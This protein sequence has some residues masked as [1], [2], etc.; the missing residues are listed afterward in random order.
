MQGVV[1]GRAA[2][3]VRTGVLALISSAFAVC[4]AIAPA[5]AQT[6]A[7][8]PPDGSYGLVDTVIFG[9]PIDLASEDRSPL[10]AAIPTYVLMTVDGDRLSFA[11]RRYPWPSPATCEEAGWC[12]AWVEALE[13]AIAVAP[14]GAVEVVAWRHDDGPGMVIDRADVDGPAI[15]QPIVSFFDGATVA[16]DGVGLA[17]TGRAPDGQMR[18]ARFLPASRARMEDAMAFVAAFE[19]SLALHDRCV[20]R[21][22]LEFDARSWTLTADEAHFLAATR[23][24]GA[25]WRIDGEIERLGPEDVESDAYR[26]L[27]ARRAAF[28]FGFVNATRPS[29]DLLAQDAA[30][31]WEAVRRD[32]R[33]AVAGP[34]LQRVQAEAFDE[35]VADVLSNESL[36]RG[37]GPEIRDWIAAHR[38]DILALTDYS[39]RFIYA[40]QHGV[41]LSSAAGPILCGGVFAEL[42]P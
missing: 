15:I 38:D 7:D 26:R 34:E 18:T 40:A 33:L 6:K 36:V 3:P 23:A 32:A 42:A 24:A 11:F 17:V 9:G 29:V 14:G 10:N 1:G 30:L 37:N 31:T 25:L 27:W 20:L 8:P 5:A 19:L 4:L 28:Q 16:R 35:G 39:I 12:Q 22:A 21:K 13:I 2:A 41:D